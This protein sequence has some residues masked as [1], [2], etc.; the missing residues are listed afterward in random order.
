MGGSVR[1]VRRGVW[2][3]R[4]YLGRDD[5]GKVRHRH[6][7]FLGGKREAPRKLNR[8]VADPEAPTGASPGSDLHL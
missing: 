3:L 8:L 4:V 1:E 7:T 2:E 6:V 5:R